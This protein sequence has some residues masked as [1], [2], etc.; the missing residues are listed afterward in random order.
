MRR[1]EFVAGV[2]VAAVPWSARAQQRAQQAQDRNFPS[3]NP[4][5]PPY[6]NGWGS[7]WRIFLELRRLGYVEGENLI[8]ERYSADGH[9]ERYANLARGRS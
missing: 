4:H 8:I 9:H 2:L 5:D 7:A 6:R 3:G 1:R